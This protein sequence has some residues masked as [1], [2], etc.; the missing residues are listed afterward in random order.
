MLHNSRLHIFQN[1]KAYNETTSEHT[2]TVN[3]RERKLCSKV[4]LRQIH[5]AK[6][7]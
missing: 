1:V 2:F 7:P 3:N 5:V 4:L 6:K